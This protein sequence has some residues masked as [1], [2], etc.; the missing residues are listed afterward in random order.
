MQ[1]PKHARAG[2]Q[3]QLAPT[4]VQRLF[5]HQTNRPASSSSR[6][7]APAPGARRSGEAK[8]ASRSYVRAPCDRGVGTTS[9]ARDDRPYRWTRELISLA[10]T[11][12][13]SSAPTLRGASGR[14]S[15]KRPIGAC[16]ATATWLRASASASGSENEQVATCVVDWWLQF[17]PAD[18]RA[19]ALSIPRKTRGH[20]CRA[21]AFVYVGVRV[22]LGLGST[23]R[24]I[25]RYLSFFS[26]ASNTRALV[27]ASQFRPVG[28]FVGFSGELGYCTIS[29]TPHSSGHRP[30]SA[31]NKS[32]PHS[33]S[34]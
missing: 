29:L 21:P 6:R 23:H 20:R 31:R 9:L 14:T 32:S 24:S 30:G 34:L 22:S 16:S 12:M 27:A 1:A 28:L 3:L 5:P 25:A 7:A 15:Q 4:L 11:R 10:R 13:V 2:G 8:E 19:L 17:E 33:T 18:A 26:L